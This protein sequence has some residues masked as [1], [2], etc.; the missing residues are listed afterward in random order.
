ML[1]MEKTY[2]YFSP[3]LLSAADSSSPLSFLVMSLETI[4]HSGKDTS[5]DTILCLWY[6]RVMERQI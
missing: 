5:A 4:R 2:R 6:G 3:C 1:V